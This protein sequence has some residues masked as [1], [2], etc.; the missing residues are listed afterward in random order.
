MKR[1]VIA[2]SFTTTA[3][4]EEKKKWGRFI[5]DEYY[6]VAGNVLNRTVDMDSVN[7]E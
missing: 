7:F 4:K 6:I 2:K 1:M 3:A 5:Y